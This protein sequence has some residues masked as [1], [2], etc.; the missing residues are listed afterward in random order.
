VA[1]PSPLESPALESPVSTPLL[2]R[3]RA[4][5]VEMPG[6]KLTAAQAQRLWGLD[7]ATCHAVLAALLDL[8][9]LSRTRTGLFIMAATTGAGQM[10]RRGSGMPG[11]SALV[12]AHHARTDPHRDPPDIC[13]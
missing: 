9:F 5:Y 8:A 6:L 4:E 2:Q 12:G 3:V 11:A 7:G 13:A 10:P 1:A